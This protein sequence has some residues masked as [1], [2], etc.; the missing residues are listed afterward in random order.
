MAGIQ[1]DLW[2]Q[3]VGDPSAARQSLERALPIAATLR[4]RDLGNVAARRLVAQSEEEMG[5]LLGPAEDRAAALDHYGKALAM[6]Q[7]DLKASVNL[8]TKIAGLQR[9]QRRYRGGARKLPQGRAVGQGLCGKE[10]G[11]PR[12]TPRRSFC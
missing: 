12:R 11:E 1:G 10:P 2:Q 5:D 8:L 7:G 6:S 4:P 3:N 9:G